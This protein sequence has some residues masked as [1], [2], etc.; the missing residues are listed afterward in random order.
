MVGFHF[1]VHGIGNGAAAVAVAV[2]VEATV[3]EGEAV[4]E[5]PPSLLPHPPPGRQRRLLTNSEL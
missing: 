3:A 2:A 1:L 4:A 5:G